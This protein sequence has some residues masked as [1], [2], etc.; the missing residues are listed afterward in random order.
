MFGFTF[1]ELILDI[2][3]FVEINLVRIDFEVNDLCL[4]S[5]LNVILTES[6]KFSL[7]PKSILETKIDSR[8]KQPNKIKTHQN[9]FL[10]S[11]INCH[12]WKWVTKHTVSKVRLG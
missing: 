5:P 11:K 6:K 1:I 9:R 7:L 3:D 12:P 4:V 8:K 2:I 10:S